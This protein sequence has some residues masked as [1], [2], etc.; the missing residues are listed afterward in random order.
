VEA[1]LVVIEGVAGSG[2]TSVA[3]RLAELLGARYEPV[4]A[5]ECWPEKD[6]VIRQLCFFYR[7]AA[8]YLEALGSSETV[9]LDNGFLT[10]YAYSYAFA[11]LHRKSLERLAPLIRASLAV[12]E[13]LAGEARCKVVVLDAD[14]AFLAARIA[15]RIDEEPERASNAFEKLMVLHTEA[16]LALLTVAQRRRLPVLRSDMY[17]PARLAEKIK[18]LVAPE[19]T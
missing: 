12:F 1:V 2:K 13:S 3:K 18:S 9:V 6:P 17:G 8:R 15:S 16:R 4:E 5:Q 7:F 10:L 11:Q 19:A 14:P